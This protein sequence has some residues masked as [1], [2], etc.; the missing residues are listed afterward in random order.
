MI[1]QLLNLSAKLLRKIANR[2]ATQDAYHEQVIE[3][4]PDVPAKGVVLIA[5]VIDPFLV[6]SPDQISNA[7]THDWETWQIAQTFL[8]RGYAVD[9]I[10]YHN[11]TFV[12]SKP[13][14]LFFAARTNFQRIAQRLP[15]SCKKIVHLDTAHWLF[16]NTAADTRLLNLQQRK[17]VTLTNIKTVERNWA[18]EHAD[19]G[20]ILG[21][22]FTISTYRYADKP[23]HRIPISAPEVYEW[24]A[25]RDTAKAANHFI[26]FG[27]SGFVH[28]GL[29]VVLEAFAGLPDLHLHVCGPFEDEPEFLAL[30]D[31]ELFHT[32]NIHAH[33]WVN[34]ASQQFL[35]IAQNCIGLVYPT[36][37]EGGGGSAITCMH[38][39]L[40]PILSVGASVDVEDFGV[41]LP[42]CEIDEIQNAVQQVAAKQPEQLE[43]MARNAWEYARKHHTKESFARAFE[44]FIDAHID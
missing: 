37:S 42:S 30:Y 29:D 15:A 8:K 9:V 27:S 38:A 7:H 35:D 16:N 33:G 3:L 5:Y 23:L 34:V 31:K 11:L 21:N 20:T 2:L 14:K 28:K 32:P 41:I 24:P 10:S 4:E 18:L 6:S 13:Y 43:A 12:P 44:T 39:G 25:Q 1:K 19:L 17:G 26:W 22:E 36:A 40:I